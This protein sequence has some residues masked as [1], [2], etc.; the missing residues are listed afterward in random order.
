V[1]TAPTIKLSGS[2]MSLVVNDSTSMCNTA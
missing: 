2:D 1:I